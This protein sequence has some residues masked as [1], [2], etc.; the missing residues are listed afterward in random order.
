MRGR[1]HRWA[2]QPIYRDGVP[3]GATTSG[4]FA[5]T[6]GRPISMGYIGDPD[7][8]DREFVMA[9]AYEIDI[10][11]ERYPAGWNLADILLE[12]PFGEGEGNLFMHDDGAVLFVIAMGRGRYR[13]VANKANALALLPA[14]RDNK[15]SDT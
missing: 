13:A 15:G 14:P 7:G 6:L 9:G 12:W 8:V 4:A 1:H 2:F 11:G 10:A 5:C 3:V